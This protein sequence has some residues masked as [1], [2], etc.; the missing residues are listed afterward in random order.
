MLPNHQLISTYSNNLQTPCAAVVSCRSVLSCAS[1]LL[2][3]YFFLLCGQ[4]VYGQVPTQVATELGAKLNEQT[5]DE[6]GI[7]Y[8]ETHIRPLLF[9]QCYGCHSESQNKREGGL[10]L[11]SA[12]GLSLGGDRGSAVVPHNLEASLLWQAVQYQDVELQMPPSAPLTPDQLDKVKRWIEIGAPLPKQALLSEMVHPSDPEAG[13]M[14][15]AFRPLDPS[16]VTVDRTNSDNASPSAID[17]YTAALRNSKGLTNAPLADRATLLRRATLI[18]HG[19]VPSPEELQ[20]FSEDPDPD[21]YTK[22][23]DRLLASPRFGERWGR[24]WLDLARYADSNGSDENFLFREAWRYRNWVLAALNQDIPLDRFTEMQLAGDQLPF[25]SLEQRDQQRIA[26][27]F[28]LLGPK[29]LLGN[30][31]ENQKMEIADELI[32]TIG[33][34]YHA[35]TLGCA[36]CHNH[37]FDPVPTRDYYALAGIFTSTQ[38]M[39]QRYMLNEQ[40]VM[41]QLVGLGEEGMAKDDAYEQYWRDRNKL[42]ERKDKAR[43]ALDALAKG[44]EELLK[45]LAIHHADAIA[46]EAL[47]TSRTLEERKTAQQK[48]GDDLLRAWN[49]PPAIPPRAM[50]SLDKP[51]PND[52]A[53]RIAGQFSQKGDVVPR[54]FL[55]VLSDLPPQTDVTA[56][57][58][59]SRVTPFSL[60]AN[61]SGRLELA[62]WLTSSSARSGQLTARVMANRIW[63]HIMGRGLVRTVDNFGR[64]GETPSHP[65][66]LDYLAGRLISNHWSIKHLIREIVLSETFQLS[67][68]HNDQNYSTDPDNIYLW[69]Y[70]RR[71]IDPEAF[72]D[73]ALQ[74]AGMLDLN[75]YESTVS[76]LG[77]QATAVGPNT[78]RRRT[79]F[80]SRSV[81]L[82]VIRNDLPEIFE[83]LDFA[84]PQVA[85]GM[86][87][88]TIVPTQG[89]F[90]LNDDQLMEAATKIAVSAGHQPDTHS[91]EQKI[92]RVYELIVGKLPNAAEQAVLK[93]TY[94]SLIASLLADQAD[95][96]LK[97]LS[98]VVHA[99]LASSRF[100]FYE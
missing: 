68:E 58:E 56:A 71:R 48:W 11:D 42:G 97:S 89:L 100:Q 99:I 60:P 70:P 33:R 51:Q 38:V 94:E 46:P 66:L 44:D 91:I 84:D 31:P 35:Q 43:E 27:G 77:D 21:A 85:T 14:H 32:D 88:Q 95:R 81:Y 19:L 18:L 55:T 3:A 80:P 61:S 57:E 15:W 28:L 1:A 50:V 23:I 93:R 6:Q 83:I 62:R 86:R 16:S 79:D 53:I 45:K 65:H 13:K 47:E 12:E 98:I 39:E 72:R 5:L 96:E 52:E 37:K 49:E 30:D 75:V 69:R 76:Y 90:L 92:E 29:V 36:R 26:T 20:Q 78:V 54:G 59:T 17:A 40:R 34:V 87:R 25:E 41:E 67:S 74:L 64:T 8:F 7:A 22:V 24:H 10:V 63:Y 82:P 73:T 9:Q 4:P 2:L